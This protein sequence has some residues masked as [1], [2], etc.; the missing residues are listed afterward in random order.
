MSFFFDNL[1]TWSSLLEDKVIRKDNEKMKPRQFIVN[2]E[3]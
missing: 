2:K 3:G 1:G